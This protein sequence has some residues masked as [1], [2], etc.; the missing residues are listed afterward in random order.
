MKNEINEINGINEINEIN[1]IIFLPK[2]GQSSDAISSGKGGHFG[3]SWAP[4]D[5]PG[6]SGNAG[7][8]FR[9]LAR[10]YFEH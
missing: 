3:D 10:P 1:E 9:N 5:F 8:I 7:G 6:I 4:R 2:F